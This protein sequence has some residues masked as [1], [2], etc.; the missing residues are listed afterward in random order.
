SRGDEMDFQSVNPELFILV[1][2]L[3]GNVIANEIP[4]NVQNAVG[5]WL[6]LVGQAILTYNAQQQYYQ[7]GPGRYFTPDSFNVDNPFCQSNQSN[8]DGMS[9]E[10]L[11]QFQE[12]L[13]QLVK[14]I[15]TLEQELKTMKQSG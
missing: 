4:L 10:Q 7:Q 1:G 3:L 5:N 8:Q 11:R 12:T 6:Q 14:R 13:E 15:E 9:V 2:E